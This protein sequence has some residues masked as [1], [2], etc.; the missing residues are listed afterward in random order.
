MVTLKEGV[1]DSLYLKK[2]AYFLLKRRER[3]MS[4]KILASIK[5]QV[6]IGSVFSRSAS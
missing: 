5:Q 4:E 2:L 1:F 6:F 3:V